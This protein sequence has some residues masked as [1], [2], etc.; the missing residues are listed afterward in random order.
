MSDAMKSL[1]VVAFVLS[2]SLSAFAA[3][4]L[5]PVE[6]TVADVAKLYSDKQEDREEIWKAFTYLTHRPPGLPN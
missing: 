4:P 2:C 3:D 5:K 1:F 6:F